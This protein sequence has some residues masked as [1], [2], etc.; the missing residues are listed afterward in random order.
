VANVSFRPLSQ[1]RKLPESLDFPDHGIIC[2]TSCDLRPRTRFVPIVVASLS[3]IHRRLEEDGR[4]RARDLFFLFLFKP[5]RRVRLLLDSDIIENKVLG[6][7]V[8]LSAHFNHSVGNFHEYRE[9]WR[10]LFLIII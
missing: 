9:P 1:R 10:L 8:H 5:K 4:A 7:N 2:A 6:I 3:A